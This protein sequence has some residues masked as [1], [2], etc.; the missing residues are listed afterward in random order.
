MND[1]NN[2]NNRKSP[3]KTKSSNSTTGMGN[4]V[5]SL[6][7]SSVGRNSPRKTSEYMSSP[8]PGIRR[9]TNF[10]K[11]QQNS[12]GFGTN[13]NFAKRNTVS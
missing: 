5:I 6:N 3:T 13:T 11:P 8:N 10:K 12:Y 7:T 9:N 4:R 1:N 2:R